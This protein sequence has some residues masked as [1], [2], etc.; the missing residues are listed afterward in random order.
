[1]GLEQPNNPST[2]SD[3]G[4]QSTTIDNTVKFKRLK[5][6]N[7]FNSISGSIGVNQSS[8]LDG[9]TNGSFP[10]VRA[11]TDLGIKLK[12]TN[13]QSIDFRYFALNEVERVATKGG[14]GAFGINRLI[15]KPSALPVGM[16]VE[17][18]S[19]ANGRINGLQL[20]VFGDL[21][22]KL[23]PKNLGPDYGWA[24][25]TTGGL[26]PG[27]IGPENPQIWG[28]VTFMGKA[29]PK[30][31]EGT[32]LLD[33][34]FPKSEDK[35]FFSGDNALKTTLHTESTLNFPAIKKLSNSHVST[36]ANIALFTNSGNKFLD[37]WRVQ[38]GLQVQFLQLDQNLTGAARKLK[39]LFR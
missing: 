37:P 1:M 24:Y 3:T 19:S 32:L 28:F 18:L 30:G 15:A 5:L 17:Q 16:I 22:T 26:R 9:S 29:L 12:L 35:K 10:W 27:E 14:V 7:G 23:I 21:P 13:N 8:A 39:D 25:V 38:G 6:I 2:A 20:G 11:L 33:F 31:L 34:R 4:A 36:K